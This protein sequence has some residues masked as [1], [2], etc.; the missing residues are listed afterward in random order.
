LAAL[1]LQAIEAALRELQ[2]AFPPINKEL[3]DCRDPLD[4]EVLEG[5]LVG[6]AGVDRLLRNRVDIFAIGQLHHWLDLNA[7]VLCGSD[8]GVRARHHQLLEATESR[9]YEQPDGG[10]RDIMEWYAINRG[11][12]VWRQATGVFI[13]LLSSPQLFIEGNHRTGALVMSYLL[14]R[15][16]E[17]PFVLTAWRSSICS[18]N[19]Y[20]T[21]YS[22][23]L[24][25]EGRGLR[26]RSADEARSASG[27][28]PARRHFAAGAMG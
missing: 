26:G 21:D 11:K 22:I 7:T 18:R 3:F 19:R 24:S 28:R 15:E 1:D 4:D 13:R 2:R 16:G 10:I 8:A 17:P 25:G 23:N 27:R 6:Y 14:C 9:F 5:M 12:S 20:R